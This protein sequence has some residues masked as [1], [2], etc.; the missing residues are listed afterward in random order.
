MTPSL[1]LGIVSDEITNDFG[2]ALQH[3]LSWGIHRYEIRCLT[4]GRV[5]NVTP[6]ESRAVRSLVR[7]HGVSITALSPGMFKSQ[8]SNTDAIEKELKDV[9]PATLELAG[10]LACPM[11]IVFGFQREAHEPADRYQRAVEYMARAAEIAGRA[12]V[13]IAIENEPGFWC[14]SGVNTRTLIRAAGSASLGANWDPC[15]GFGTDEVPYPAGYTAIKDVIMNVHV[16]DTARGAL[17]QCVPVGDGAIDWP[18]QITALVQDRL[19]PHVTIETHC[20][21]LVEN[22]RHN[23]EVL[24]GMIVR[25]SAARTS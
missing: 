4:S 7:D 2:A 11:I 25:A 21:P 10:Q 13:R 8:L 14:D 3:G 17:I 19:V 20:L 12:G 6:E 15:N 22:S 23:V 5:P 9:L 1:E 16:K 18:G 24:R